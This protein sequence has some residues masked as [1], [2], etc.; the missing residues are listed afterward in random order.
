MEAVVSRGVI[1]EVE[2]TE[3]EVPVGEAPVTEVPV[4]EPLVAVEGHLIVNHV[5]LRPHMQRVSL[6]NPKAT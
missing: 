5:S 2:G 6:D 1:E 3:G 4:C